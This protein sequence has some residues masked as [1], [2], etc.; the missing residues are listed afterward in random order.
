MRPRWGLS[1]GS[2]WL[3][4][5]QSHSLFLLHITS[6]SSS[7]LDSFQ[8]DAGTQLGIPGDRL[9]CLSGATLGREKTH[10]CRHCSCCVVASFLAGKI[11]Y[12]RCRASVYSR[13]PEPSHSHHCSRTRSAWH[14]QA[15]SVR[16]AEWCS[17][18]SLCDGAAVEVARQYL[19]LHGWRQDHSP[20][21]G[22]QCEADRRSDFERPA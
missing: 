21:A 11:C 4:H 9:I 15:A 12:T 5:N 17:L 2:C 1:R 14:S 18:P 3:E 16:R 10:C 19:R 20:V 6:I 13:F 22:G 7:N 8:S